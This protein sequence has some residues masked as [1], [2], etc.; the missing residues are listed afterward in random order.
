MNEKINGLV[1][2]RISLMDSDFNGFHNFVKSMVGST[3]KK[4]DDS[5]VTYYHIASF[6]DIETGGSC[7]Y[8]IAPYATLKGEQVRITEEN[9]V[10]IHTNYP[11]VVYQDE[12]EEYIP[13][14]R[15]EYEKALSNASDILFN[16]LC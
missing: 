7:I 8:D 4:T 6:D 5:S 16:K 15:D 1:A 11:V 10:F 13:I 3:Y 14:C 12:I 2:E 9:N